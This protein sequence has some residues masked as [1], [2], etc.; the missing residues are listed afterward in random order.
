MGGEQPADFHSS[1]KDDVVI[2]AIH[3]GDLA[4]PGFQAV[5]RH[6]CCRAGGHPDI[7]AN[8][9]GGLDVPLE[10]GIDG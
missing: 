1:P 6:D 3:N 5:V 7:G 4:S 8:A 2:I 9:R 10:Q